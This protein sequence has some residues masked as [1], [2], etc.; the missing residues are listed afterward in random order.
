MDKTKE[1]IT[2]YVNPYIKVT[3]QDTHE[4]FTPEKINSHVQQHTHRT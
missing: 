2:S 4:N 1:K 3:W